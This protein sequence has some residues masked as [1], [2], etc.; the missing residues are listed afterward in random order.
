MCTRIKLFLII[1]FFDFYING[2]TLLLSHASYAR[3]IRRD[4]DDY[5]STFAVEGVAVDI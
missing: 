3:T 4:T 5:R 2:V 1:A